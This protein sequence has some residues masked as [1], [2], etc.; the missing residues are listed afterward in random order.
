VGRP[1]PLG[2]AK[3]SYLLL[4]AGV[5]GILISSNS[6]LKNNRNEKILNQNTDKGIK[7]SHEN[8]YTYIP[9]VSR[10]F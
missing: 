4:Q 6:F 1:Y 8:C 2:F 7:S 5:R 3:K 10:V 9:T